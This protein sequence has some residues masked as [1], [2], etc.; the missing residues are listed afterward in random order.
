MPGVFLLCQGEVVRSYRHQSVADRPDYVRF[1]I[2][3]F[4]Q[5]EMQS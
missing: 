1:S 2:S 5:L 3:E 4:P